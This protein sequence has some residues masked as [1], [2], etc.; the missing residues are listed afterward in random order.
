LGQ[1]FEF[2]EIHFIIFY[3][4]FSVFRSQSF[5]LAFPAA[6]KRISTQAGLRVIQRFI[7]ESE[8]IE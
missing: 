8:I 1:L 3:G 5:C 4:S 2:I 6:K 7:I